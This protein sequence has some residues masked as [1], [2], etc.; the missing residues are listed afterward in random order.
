LL[1]S[2]QKERSTAS[3]WD[4]MALDFDFDSDPDPDPD[5]PDQPDAPF[6]T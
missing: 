4:E 3:A 6:D 2:P 5:A 1:A